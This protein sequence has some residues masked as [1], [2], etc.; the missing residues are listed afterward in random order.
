MKREKTVKNRIQQRRAARKNAR[1]NM[2]SLF[3]RKAKAA[4]VKMAA[5]ISAAKAEFLAKG[6]EAREEKVT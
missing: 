3:R 2:R 6:E 5:M 4:R 1:K